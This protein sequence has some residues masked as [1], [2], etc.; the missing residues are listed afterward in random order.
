MLIA[1]IGGKLQGLEAVYLAQKAS[2]QTLV[3]DKNPD[4]PAAKLCDQFMEFEFSSDNLFPFYGSKIDLIIPAIEDKIVLAAI[5]TWAQTDNI[6]LAFDIDAYLLSSSKIKSD[7]LFQKMCLPAPRHWPD[8]SFP[9]VL[10]PDQASGSQGVEIIDNPTYF[11]SR[12]PTR[13]Q[14]E[15]MIVQEFLEGT[16]SSIEI[17]GRPGNYHAIQV[18]DLGMDE[19]YDCKKVTTPTQLSKQYINQFTEIAVAIAEK[20]KLF[21]I[22]DVEVILHQNRLKLLEIDARLP[23]QTPIAVYWSTGINM[24]KLL[25][26]L[27]VK[28]SLNPSPK[29]ERSVIVEH[30]KVCDSKI[31]FLGEHIMGQD[32]PLVLISNFFGANEAITSFEG[33]K[34]QWVSTMIFSGASHDEINI[35]REAC[36]KK[37]IEQSKN[38]IGESVN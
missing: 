11:S 18:T 9:V 5:K 22:M 38:F 35:K 27:F 25:V 14:M 23:S 12:F 8:C 1:V 30:I 7:T 34:H 3:I 32:G 28:K 37:I 31:E 19:D 36:Y 24:V 6:P 4:A 29:H 2:Y 21:G 33:G 15:G 20:I 13:L 16:S 26:D 10:K 17:L